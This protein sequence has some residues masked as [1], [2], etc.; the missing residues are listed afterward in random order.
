MRREKEIERLKREEDET[1]LA[2]LAHRPDIV[3]RAWGQLMRKRNKEKN[4]ARIGTPAP[5]HLPG[6]TCRRC[7]R[8]RGKKERE[9][10]REGKS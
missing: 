4:E 8:V 2:M 10:M 5:A 7:S 6:C 9:R 3:G 1:L